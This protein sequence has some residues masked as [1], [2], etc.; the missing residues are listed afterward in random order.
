MMMRRRRRRRRRFDGDLG[1]TLNENLEVD[2]FSIVRMHTINN[3]KDLRVCY[4][5][6]FEAI[7]SIPA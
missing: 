3:E 4:R 6:Y 5:I 7:F 1:G 2:A